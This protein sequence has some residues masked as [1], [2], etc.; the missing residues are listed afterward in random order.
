LSELD[1]RPSIIKTEWARF[2]GFVFLHFDVPML[3]SPQTPADF[4]VR[5]QNLKRNLTYD[6]WSTPTKLKFLVLSSDANPGPD[7]SDYVS[8]EMHLYDSEGNTCNFW[9]GEPVTYVPPL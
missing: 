1:F 5:S 4:F 6:S 8:E 3:E 2:A 7:T 9:S